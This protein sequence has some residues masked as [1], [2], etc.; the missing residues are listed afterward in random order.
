MSKWAKWLAI[1]CGAWIGFLLLLTGVLSNNSAGTAR[2][3]A[4]NRA[5]GG[6]NSQVA[7]P[8]CGPGSHEFDECYPYDP[9]TVPWLGPGEPTKSYLENAKIAGLSVEFT[10][11][12]WPAYYAGDQYFARVWS[13]RHY[14]IPD[15]TGDSRGLLSVARGSIRNSADR[16]AYEHLEAFSFFIRSNL[17]V[18]KPDADDCMYGELAAF[19]SELV[20]GSQDEARQARRCLADEAR[21]KRKDTE[22]ERRI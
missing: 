14:K 18:L 19:G 20:R 11:G 2:D 17:G 22:R 21:V 13:R 9:S 16:G 5:S 6:V 12:A 10:K 8:A 1:G 4:G 15:W 3:N 7:T